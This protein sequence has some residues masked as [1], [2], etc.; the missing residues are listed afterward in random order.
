MAKATLAPNPKVDW[1]E[2]A[3]DYATVRDAIEATYPELFK[4][5]NARMFTPGGFWKGNDAAHRQWKT[6]SGK[7]EFNLPAGLNAAGFDDAEGRY[8]LMTL[9]SNDQFNTTIYGY[10]DRFRGIKGTREVVLMNEGDMAKAK[11]AEG[12]TVSLIGDSGDNSQRRVD[13]LRVVRYD[14][15]AGCLGAYYPECNVLIPLAHHALES[16]VPAG[17]SVPVRLE[18]AR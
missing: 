13:G 7:A 12:D 3:G 6:E 18:K 8:R 9:R 17:K 10:H 5:F 1:D 15:P 4:D 2:W 16:H 14:I 11:L